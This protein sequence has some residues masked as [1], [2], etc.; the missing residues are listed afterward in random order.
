[1]IVL[2]AYSVAVALV[3]AYG[4]LRPLTL[5]SFL[6]ATVVLGTLVVLLVLIVIDHKA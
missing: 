4:R 2:I 6:G 3:T 5:V 1:M